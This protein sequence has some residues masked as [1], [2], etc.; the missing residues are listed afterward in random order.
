MLLQMEAGA[1]NE[2]PQKQGKEIG[3]QQ[4]FKRRILSRGMT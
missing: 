1:D 4:I 2:G 3:L